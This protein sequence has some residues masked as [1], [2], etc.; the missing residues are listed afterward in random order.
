MVKVLRTEG[1]E[2]LILFVNRQQSRW[3]GNHKTVRFTELCYQIFFYLSVCFTIVI[4]IVLRFH[5]L[6]VPSLLSTPDRE[7]TIV[8]DLVDDVTLR[9]MIF[10]R[11]TLILFKS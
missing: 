8:S 11:L 9:L 10:P 6:L 2:I 4:T 1:S 7:D 5:L 3:V